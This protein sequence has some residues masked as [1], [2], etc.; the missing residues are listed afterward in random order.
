MNVP[1]QNCQN[2]QVMHIWVLRRLQVP[3]YCGCEEALMGPQ[4]DGSYY[5]GQD[6]FGDVPDSDPPTEDLIQ[7]GHAVNALIQTVNENKGMLTPVTLWPKA[8]DLL[9]TTMQ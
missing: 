2:P 4:T 6:G 3:V 5:H 7:Q 1:E 8:S 9:E